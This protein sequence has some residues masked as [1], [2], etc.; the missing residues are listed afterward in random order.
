MEGVGCFVANLV[1][2]AVVAGGFCGGGGE[3]VGAVREPG[4]GVGD[5]GVEGGDFGGGGA[6]EG[7]FFA[8][9][10]G[11]GESRVW[12]G[13]FEDAGFGRDDVF[14]VGWRDGEGGGDGDGE[15]GDC[16]GGGEGEGV[17]FAVMEDRELK[18]GFWVGGR[19]RWAWHVGGICWVYNF[20]H[21][22]ETD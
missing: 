21:F 7:D 16:G 15:V 11:E 3:C 9:E 14:L 22:R 1:D 19:W 8:D 10:G 2:G 4:L 18:G 6:E 17:W 5:A 13:R 20:W 12:E